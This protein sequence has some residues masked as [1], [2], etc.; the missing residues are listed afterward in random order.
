V[1]GKNYGERDVGGGKGRGGDKVTGDDKVRR[2]HGVVH[3]GHSGGT[4][5]GRNRLYSGPAKRKTFNNL[6]GFMK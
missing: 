3:G 1:V 6:F 2:G 5:H 4:G